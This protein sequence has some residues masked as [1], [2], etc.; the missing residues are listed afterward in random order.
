MSEKPPLASHGCCF[1]SASEFQPAS[2]G[3]S[4]L[5]ITRRKCISV[6]LINDKRLRQ[7][8]PAHEKDLHC[9]YRVTT[10]VF[11]DNSASPRVVTE[12]EATRDQLAFSETV[13]SRMV[14][15]G[16]EKTDN[17]R[18]TR[19]LP[20]LGCLSIL[21]RY[22]PR[23]RSRN[24]SVVCVVSSSPK[25]PSIFHHQRLTICSIVEMVRGQILHHHHYPAGTGTNVSDH[26]VSR[27]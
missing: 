23:T 24:A 20:F 12:A 22:F 7:Q 8:P 1:P 15:L 13:I 9:T 17:G 21:R 4:A 26:I 11:S 3:P 16:I 6:I 27:L 2:L 19:W 5:R 10:S 25:V 14:V 18:L